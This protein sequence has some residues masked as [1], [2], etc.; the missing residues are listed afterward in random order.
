MK[1][2]GMIVLSILG[3]ALVLA[4]APLE[5]G[6]A[7]KRAGSK[8]AEAPQLD[9]LALASLLLRDGHP[10]RAA[11][12]L[13]EVDLDAV[14]EGFEVKR[15]YMLYGIVAL[16]LGD[17][18]LAREKIERAI[19]AGET[20][21]MIHVFHAQALFGQGEHARA[22][23]AIERAGD[24]AYRYAGTFMLK[25][26]SHWKLGQR[27][28]AFAA[29]TTGLRVY[30]GDLELTR[31]RV[32]L[33]VDMGLYQQAV[34]EGTLVVARKDATESDLAAI[35]EA[36]IKGGQHQKA[37]LLLEEARL[38]RFNSEMIVIQLARAYLEAGHT[39]TAARLFREASRENPKFTLDAAELFRRGGRPNQAL[40]LNAEVLDQKDKVR[41]RLGLLI[42]VE[43]FEEALG[44]VPRL[45]RLGLMSEDA[46]S[47]AV[48]FAYF[49]TGSFERAE[50]TL[51]PIRDPA[52]FEK[53]SA[54][55]RAMDTCAAAGWQCQ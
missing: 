50:R 33:L 26:Q 55:R 9:V 3:T 23:A 44:L 2:H 1:H 24:T 47:Y 54:L 21:P 34:A 25:A 40:H 29:L 12:T 41:Q 11:A 49:K 52:L 8:A 42:E 4:S 35:A 15:Y 22:I 30:P 18:R 38:R 31:N 53:A 13:A 37:I 48:A 39:L 14:A 16:K 7:M 6:A 5:V 51:K 32:L 10:D 20:D 46:V 36:L 43:R 17:H 27:P 45:E 28:E 19:T